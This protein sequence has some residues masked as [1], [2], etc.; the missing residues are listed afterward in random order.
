MTLLHLLEYSG[1]I[2]IDG[3]DIAHISRQQLRSRI[4][5][6]PQDPIELDGSVRDNLAPFL[7]SN[8]SH[9]ARQKPINDDEMEEALSKVGIWKHISSQGGLDASLSTVGLSQGQKQLLCLAR[10]ILHNASTGSKILLVDE[11]TSNV[12][13]ETDSRMQAVMADAFT[14][15]TVL[16]IAHRLKTLEDVDVVLE[17]DAGSVVVKRSNPM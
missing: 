5:T 3:I 6:L 7:S 4:T 12:D 2:V 17:M 10:A 8:P 11:A 16:T 1:S 15:C 9:D 13:Q 14:G